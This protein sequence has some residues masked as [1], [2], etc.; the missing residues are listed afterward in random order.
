LA[1]APGFRSATQLPQFLLRNDQAT[2]TEFIRKYASAAQLVTGSGVCFRA[3]NYHS[4]HL[5]NRWNAN[6]PKR[7]YGQCDRDDGQHGF[8]VDVQ[9]TLHFLTRLAGSS[10]P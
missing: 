10:E 3:A 5:C 2:D 6:V 7:D 4:V 1:S 9:L 8:G